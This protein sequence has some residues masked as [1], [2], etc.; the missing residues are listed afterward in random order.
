[1]DSHLKTLL[2]ALPH[3]L[4]ERT[5][6]LNHQPVAINGAFVLYWMHHAVRGHE[7]PAL[8]TALWVADRLALPV[9]VYQGLGGCHPY[10]SDRHH[11]FILEGARDVEKELNR[12]GITYAFHLPNEPADQT[13]LRELMARAALTLTEEFPAPPFKRWTQRLAARAATTWWAVDT[14]CI[15]PMQLVLEPY[16]RAFQFRKANWDSYQKRIVNP[17]K[18][19]TATIRPFHGRLGFNP[20]KLATADIAACCAKCR[21]DHTVGPVYH[22]RGGSKAG[23]DRWERFTEHG[24]NDYAKTRNDA[25]IPFPSGVS[26]MSAYLHH[27]HV[28]PFRIV[29]EVASSKARGAQKYLDEILIW[30]ELGHNHC[31]Y[32][33]HPDTLHALPSWAINTLEDHR[34]DPRQSIYPWETLA[35]ARTGDPL[36]DA[37]QQSL[38]LHGELHNNVRMT[39]GKAIV[40]WT[41]SPREALKI[42]IDLNHRFALDGSDPNS[43]AGIL[44]CLGLFDRPFT[45]PQPI[46]GTTRPRSTR[47]HAARLNLSK[48]TARVTQPACGEPIRV[49]VIGAGLSGLTAARILADHGHRVRIYEKARGPGGRLSTRRYGSS[50]FDHGAQYF[51]VR[52]ERFKKWVDSWRET[53]VVQRW[54]ARIGILRHGDIGA[55]RRPHDRFVG[56]PGMSAL[57]RHLAD[58]LDIRL[59]TCIQHVRKNLNE[60]VLVDNDDN[61]LGNFD[62]LVVTPPPRQGEQLLNNQTPLANQLRAVT[63]TPCWAV[64]L[65]FAM[66]LDLP[67]DGLFIHDADIAWAARNSSKPGRGTGETWVLHATA[68]WSIAHLD[69]SPEDVIPR[70]MTSFSTATGLPLPEPVLSAAHRWR[71]AQAQSPLTIGC[72]WDRQSKIGICGDWCYGSRIEGAFLS[73]TAMAGRILAETPW[74]RPS[75]E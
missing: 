30:R 43:Y 23:Y 11:T 41:R 5:R 7:N 46:I 8:D 32:H 48:Y 56:V 39:W 50:A 21:I 42:M 27:G 15:L 6:V 72:L 49:A 40:Q 71:Y 59:D 2:G 65:T 60:V 12:R 31:F 26:R 33:D 44:W 17:Y 24:L 55:E 38:I 28:S 68:A 29:R 45:P 9:L 37:A 74:L 16:A 52:D 14:A 66:P 61:D 13:P 62:A 57:T 36:W 64:L 34:Q 1:M 54:H 25:A 75:H 47:A 51:T 70:L 67:V 35:R 73:G 53:G 22:T 18:A 69:L 3:H 10:N 20:I 19:S 63:M 4:L 58:G